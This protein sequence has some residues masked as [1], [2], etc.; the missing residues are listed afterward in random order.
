MEDVDLFQLFGVLDESAPVRASSLE[1]FD[2][3]QF[4]D[5]NLLVMPESEPQDQ[6][7]PGIGQFI[8]GGFGQCSQPQYLQH[9]FEINSHRSFCT[10]SIS[11]NAQSSSSASS[12]A[13]PSSRSTS[14][15]TNTHTSDKLAQQASTTG[16]MI[17]ASTVT[18]FQ[19]S[20]CKEIFLN[21]H[22]Y[23]KHRRGDCTSRTIHRCEACDRTFTL[24]KDLKRHQGSAS[25]CPA[26]KKLQTRKQFTCI[27][28]SAYTRKDIL[29]RHFQRANA[30]DGDSVH[31]F[32]T[33]LPTTLNAIL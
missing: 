33:I 30:R 32:P 17:I 23:R 26:A 19:C 13:I 14:P 16:K 8:D 7:P 3:S 9:N 1:Q 11:A 20:T 27:C 12:S 4:I 6:S 15:S 31:R 25:S 2:M 28:G 21:E 5:I 18:S 22:R 24:E 10:P 29:L